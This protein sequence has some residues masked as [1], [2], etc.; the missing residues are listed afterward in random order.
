[1]VQEVS[2]KY[3]LITHLIQPQLELNMHIPHGADTH[4]EQY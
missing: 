1:M 2:L 3:G 4:K